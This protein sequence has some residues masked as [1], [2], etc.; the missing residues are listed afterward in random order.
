M[1]Q[2]SHCPACLGET[3]ADVVI[4]HVAPGLLKDVV[5]MFNRAGMRDDEGSRV[6]IEVV[7]RDWYAP[8]HVDLVTTREWPQP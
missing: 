8:N 4:I 3:T 2:R 1:S 5:D 6:T 7:N